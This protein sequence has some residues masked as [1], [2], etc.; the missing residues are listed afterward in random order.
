M[1][2]NRAGHSRNPSFPVDFVGGSQVRLKIL[3]HLTTHPS[4]PSQLAEMD[5]KHVSHVSRALSELKRRGLVEPVQS[6][7]RERYYRAT[8]YGYAIYATLVRTMK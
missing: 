8:N 2:L 5:S 6:G 1:T 4:T 7:S 3:N